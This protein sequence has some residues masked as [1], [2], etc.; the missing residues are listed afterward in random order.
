VVTHQVATGEQPVTLGQRAHIVVG[1]SSSEGTP[2]AFSGQVADAGGGS[3]T[4]ASGQ[5]GGV[6][7]RG[8]LGG[9]PVAVVGQDRECLD[10]DPVLGGGVPGGVQAPRGAP[11]VF[12]EG[13]ELRR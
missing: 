4:L 5:V 6:C 11:Y 7:L 9:G 10:R 12:Q 8:D 1:C 2:D 13:R 3:V